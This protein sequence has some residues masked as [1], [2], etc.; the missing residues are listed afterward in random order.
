MREAVSTIERSNKDTHT[1]VSTKDHQ[2]NVV[3][4]GKQLL[5]ISPVVARRLAVTKQ[6]LAGREEAP[7]LT[8]VCHQLACIQIDPINVVARNPLL[9]LWS[10]LGVYDVADLEAA[11]WQDKTLFEYWAHA[12]SIVLTADFPIHQAQMRRYL[13]GNSRWEQRARAWLEHNKSFRDYITQALAQHGPLPV[14][15]IEDRAVVPWKSTGWTA[16]RNVSVMLNLLWEGGEITVARRQGTGFGTKKLW[17][18]TKDHLPQWANYAPLPTEQVVS[19]AAQKALKALGVGRIQDI[20]NHFIRGCYPHLEQTIE[21]LV[22]NG[23]VLPLQ[24]QDHNGLWPETWYI[25]ADDYPLLERLQKDS[26]QPRTTLLSPFDNLIC[27]RQRTELLFNFVYRSEIYVP[28]AKRQYGYYVMPIL[29]G[30]QL[31]GRLDPKMDRKQK[32][33]HIHAV[34]AED[35]APANAGP[36]INQ[37][38]E[39]LAQFLGAQEIIYGDTVP[40]MWQSALQ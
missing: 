31:I 37:A 4:V 40:V 1:P 9:V 33:L 8:A 12:A 20:R 18:L 15:E 14:S 10:R 28:K 24:I 25:H 36:A 19:L 16:G 17:A 32:R 3:Q 29:H 13:Q 34:F 38:I 30:D 7:S 27:D 22:Q 23:R 35:K 5:L 2:A 6:W 39:S 26:W 11:L 21:E